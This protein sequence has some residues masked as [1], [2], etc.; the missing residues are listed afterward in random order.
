MPQLPSL[1]TFEQPTPNF[2]DVYI[3]LMGEDVGCQMLIL[4]SSLVETIR[5]PSRREP[6]AR[7]K[8]H[9][10]GDWTG[11]GYPKVL[12]GNHSARRPTEGKSARGKPGTSL[13]QGWQPIL[14]AG[15]PRAG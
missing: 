15:V 14:L 9:S 13:A 1:V 10:P 6:C 12:M 3:R 2:L 5:L 8:V 4:R 7:L 11:M